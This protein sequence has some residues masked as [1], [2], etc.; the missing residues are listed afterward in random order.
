VPELAY[1]IVDVFSAR[2]LAGNALCVVLDPCPP[3]TMAALAREVNLS[4]TTFPILDRRGPTGDERI[5]TIDRRDAA[6]AASA[7]SGP[8]GGSYRVRIFTPT[9]ELP[10]AGH[11]TLGTAWALGPGRWVQTSP[12]A[13]VVVESD[14]G[15]ARMVQPVP[16]LTPTPVP[17]AAAAVGLTRA[18]GAW[19]AEAGG[20]RHLI[21][22]TDEPLTELSPDLRAVASAAAATSTT[23]VAAV[24]RI[25]AANLHVRVFVPHMGVPE[26]PGTGSAAGPIG[27]LAR[28]VWGTAR[29]V[30]IHQGAE[31]G[32]P[33]LIEVELGDDGPV[34]S[35]RV[36][37]CAEGRFTLP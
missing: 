16:T 13:T 7:E 31:V 15:G 3:G 25:D 12:G 24:G 37:A 6:D 27:L 32:R 22:A 23:T 29:E 20:L 4:E 2:P 19:V 14:A 1:R 21:V 18:E 10:F 33:C 34:V 35:G 5:P 11:P 9:G 26:D 8:A 36:T 17:A 28:T 30:T